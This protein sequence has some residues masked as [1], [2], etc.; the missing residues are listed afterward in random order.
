MCQQ[1]SSK[2]KFEEFE[3]ALNQRPLDETFTLML[4]LLGI[5]E[6]YCQTE[7]CLWMQNLKERG[8]Y[9]GIGSVLVSVCSLNR[10]DQWHLSRHWLLEREKEA[11]RIGRS[12]ISEPI[13]FVWPWYSFLL[14]SLNW[15]LVK[16]SSQRHCLSTL[17]PYSHLKLG[18]EL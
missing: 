1:V 11:E 16:Q 15:L 12:A 8:K 13:G 9:F 18:I 3:E 2:P 5:D 17:S 4:S 10:I 6:N 14:A 7:T